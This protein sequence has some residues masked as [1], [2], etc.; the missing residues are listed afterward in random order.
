MASCRGSRPFLDF[1]SAKRNLQIPQAKRTQRGLSEAWVTLPKMR[2]WVTTPV[3]VQGF[4]T[5]LSDW[6]GK[7]D[8]TTRHQKRPLE[9]G[10]RPISQAY[11]SQGMDKKAIVP[12]K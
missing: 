9:P 8:G 7:A 1:Q 6:K 3:G 10:G 5:V 12:Q 4:F 11:A 2:C